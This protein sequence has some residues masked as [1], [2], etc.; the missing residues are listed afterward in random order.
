LKT[1][2]GR[3]ASREQ[4]VSFGR[5]LQRLREAAGLTQEE[6]AK[7]ANLSAKGISDL[8]RGERKHRYP[9]TVRPPAEALK[10]SEGER[11]ALIATIPKSSRAPARQPP[12]PPHAATPIACAPLVTTPQTARRAAR[13]NSTPGT[14]CHTFCGAHGYCERIVE[15]PASRPVLLR[16][17]AGP[18]A[19]GTAPGRRSPGRLFRGM[20]GRHRR[21]GARRH[22]VRRKRDGDAM[23]RDFE[24]V[25]P[26]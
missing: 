2:H 21:D 10:L 9:H 6:L 8:E 26:E 7:K 5:R 24:R 16:A 1:K 4:D 20:A 22:F 18:G 3:H 14:V 15:L 25:T 19:Q 12:V 11:A 13:T 23:V 17:F